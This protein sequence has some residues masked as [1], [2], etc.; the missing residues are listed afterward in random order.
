MKFTKRF[1]QKYRPLSKYRQSVFRFFH[2]I[3]SF[4]FPPPPPHP[5]FFSYTYPIYSVLIFFLHIN[6]HSYVLSHSFEKRIKFVRILK[7][8]TLYTSQRPPNFSTSSHYTILCET[9]SSLAPIFQHFHLTCKK[10]HKLF[11]SVQASKALHY[12]DDNNIPI[13]SR[14]LIY[15]ECE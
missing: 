4:R 12:H 14:R 6:I 11:F 7:Y 10:K 8:L 2:K 5:S 15:D 13:Q 1:Q 9:F 3:N